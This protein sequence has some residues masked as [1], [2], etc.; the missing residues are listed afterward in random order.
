VKALWTAV[1]VA[2]A[3]DAEP[4]VDGLQDLLACPLPEPEGVAA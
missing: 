2:V 4:A 1:Q 3:E